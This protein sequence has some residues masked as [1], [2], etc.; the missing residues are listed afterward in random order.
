MKTRFVYLDNAAT[1][2][3]DQEVVE[4]MLPYL[5]ERFGNPSSLHALG[6]EA[7][8]AL[9]NARERIA[10]LLDNEPDRIIFTPSGSASNNLLV[11]GLLPRQPGRTLLVTALEHPSISEPVRAAS[12]QGAEVVT[13]RNDREGRIDLDH[14]DAMHAGRIGGG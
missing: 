14:L 2:Q 1:T 4:A 10:R 8:R 6:L 7:H 13:L 3:P 12:Q 11:K 5:R 9:E